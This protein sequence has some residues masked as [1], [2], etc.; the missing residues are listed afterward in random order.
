MLLACLGIAVDC[1]NDACISSIDRVLASYSRWESCVDV[2]ITLSRGFLN[3]CYV[4]SVM[5]D[6]PGDVYDGL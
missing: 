2:V 6:N 4:Q 5:S 1:Q 3:S